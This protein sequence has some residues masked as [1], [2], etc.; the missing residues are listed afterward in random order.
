M[1]RKERIYLDKLKPP[2]HALM[3][4]LP[5]RFVSKISRCAIHHA[6]ADGNLSLSFILTDGERL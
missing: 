3:H 1:R 2:R 6:A 4:R 5:A